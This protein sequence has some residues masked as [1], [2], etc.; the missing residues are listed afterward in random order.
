MIKG[1]DV[2]RTVVRCE[3]D[4]MI[5]GCNVNRTVVRCEQDSMIKRGGCE[6][7]NMINEFDV[8]STA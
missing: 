6:K 3:Q 2:N 7:D 4:S 8:R 1:R 5:K